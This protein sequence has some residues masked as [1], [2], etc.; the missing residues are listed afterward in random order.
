MKERTGKFYVRKK[1]KNKNY[2]QCPV[3]IIF[4]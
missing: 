3:N 2:I 1:F 4:R